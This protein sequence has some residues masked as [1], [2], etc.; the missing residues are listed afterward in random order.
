[1]DEPVASQHIPTQLEQSETES[2]TL[3]ESVDSL[4]GTFESAAGPKA[5][6]VRSLLSIFTQNWKALT[7]LCIV[8]FFMLVGIIA[9]FFITTD[10]NAFSSDILVPPSAAHWFGTTQTG[11]DVFAQVV[12]GTRSS[13]F[14]GLATGLV[15]TFLSILVGI[16]A[17][18][19]GGI[20]DDALTL[21]TN[22]FFLLPAFVLAVIVAAYSPVKGPIVIAALLA[23]TN[24]SYQARVLRAQTLS[25]RKRDFVE[26]AK[27]NGESTW[28]ILAYEIL[29]NEI[30]IVA[31]GFI[32]TT[33]YVILAAA[34]L[35][36]L[37]LG[38]VTSVDWGTMFYWAQNSGA[39]LQGAWWWFAPPG[40][41]I[42]LLGTGF[43][44]INFGIDEIADP[45]L[46]A[47]PG[48]K[49]K[50]SRF[51]AFRLRKAQQA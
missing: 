26:A 42:A 44:L 30:A 51:S 13:V 41:C 4:V 24:W 10:P 23:L 50:V 5:Q 14:W 34:G 25:I 6:Q 15:S 45:R 40:L 27:A 49:Q 20:V 19:L 28:R 32:G 43:A 47:E 18:Y 1:M 11:Q 12:V 36:F 38:N 46:R 29:P 39:L 2:R 3:E 8:L 35:E 37:G 33:L 22:I 17:G 16:T 48:V 31:A 9:P 7:G 21:L